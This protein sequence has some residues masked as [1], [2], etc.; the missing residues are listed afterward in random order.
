MLCEGFAVSFKEFEQIFMMNEAVFSIW[1]TD[2]NGMIDC[3][4]FFTVLI[5]FADGRVEDKLR[6]LLDL[7]DFD[8]KGYL[9]EVDLH[10]M[11]Y[12]IVLSTVKLFQIDSIL[13]SQ[14]GSVGDIAVK[15]FMECIRNSYPKN[16]KLEIKDLFQFASGTVLVKEFFCFTEVIK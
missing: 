9:E 10:F 1:D 3:I 14:P 16:P 5:V 2:S 4:E 8:Q 15:Q 7:Y 6:L 13:P 12:T 11:A